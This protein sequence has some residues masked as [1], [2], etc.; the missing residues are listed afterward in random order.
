MATPPHPRTWV[1]LAMSVGVFCV[2]LDAF[3]LNFALPRIGADLGAPGDGAQWAV[4]GYL[5]STGTLMLGAGRLGDLFGRRGPLVLG[6][7]LFGAASVGCAL[8]TSLPMLVAAR[9]VQ[10][11]GSAVPR[12]A[13]RRVGLARRREP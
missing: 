9:A 10:G 13:R 1:L 12:R 7:S 5:L 4:S 6:L 8:A 2:Q 11:A 3:A